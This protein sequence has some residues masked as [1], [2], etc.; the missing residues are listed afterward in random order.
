MKR[1]ISLF[2]AALLLVVLSSQASAQKNELSG[3]WKIDRSKTQKQDDWPLLIGITIRIS[4][5]SLYTERL[6]ELIDGQQYPFNEALTLDNK[7]AAT[8]VYDMPRKMKAQWV[9]AESA[10]K[11]ESTTTNYSNGSPV[12]FVSAETWKADP[13]TQTLTL[14]FVNKISTSEVPG[15]LV[16]TR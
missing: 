12:D 6:Y 4:G 13:S 5:D 8:V 3:K 9:P 11:F 7:E 16:F 1:S 15:K 2:I 10:L 14:S